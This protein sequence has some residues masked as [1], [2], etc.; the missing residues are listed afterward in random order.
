MTVV[1]VLSGGFG[2]ICH[3]T[4]TDP[5]CYFMEVCEKNRKWADKDALK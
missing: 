5:W 1:S 2:G 3:D 4:E